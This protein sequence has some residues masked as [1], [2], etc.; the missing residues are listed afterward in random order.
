[1]NKPNILLIY[2]DQMREPMWFPERTVLDRLLPSLARLR[3]GA[4]SFSHCYC[5]SAACSPSRASLLTG[6]YAHQHGIM[7]NV[8]GTATPSLATGFPTWGDSL[9]EFGY[10][11]NWFGK[12]HLTAD[13]DDPNLYG[14]DAPPNALMF[15]PSGK[16]LGVYH[17]PVIVKNFLGWLED[18][19][20]VG[21]WAATVSLFNPHDICLHPDFHDEC[22]NAD[23]I[24]FPAFFDSMPPN[25]ESPDELAQNRKPRLHLARSR[26]FNAQLGIGPDN[27]GY[28]EK[29]AGHANAYLGFHMHLD[30]QVGRIYDVLDKRPTL[31]DNTIIVFVSDHGE[32]NGSHGLRQKGD[33]AY[34][35]GIRVPLIVNDPTGRWTAH[36]QTQRNQLTSMVDVH[37]LLLTLT[38]GGDEWR[39]Q[40]RFAHVADRLDMASIL[41]DPNAPGRRYITHTC[42][43]LMSPWLDDSGAA[44]PTHVLALRTQS[45]KLAVCSHW[46]PGTIE[47]ADDDQDWELYDY[48]DHGGRCE[49]VNDAGAKPQLQT[50]L[51]ELLVSDALPNEL[52]KPLPSPLQPIHKQAI[53]EYVASVSV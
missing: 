32:L 21:P 44:M 38:C 24:E 51:F 47:M 37:A 53:A 34:D 29:W 52:R 26:Q 46:A 1:M 4:V 6:L 2:V 17:D 41:K 49:I 39:T 42:D 30:R 7:T 23:G 8:D 28:R 36:T 18:K 43:Q 22:F 14:F 11:T 31:R 19:A 3:Q 16:G 9:R 5:D 27:I 40:P 33:C 50:E 13:G 20:H 15:D 25:Y 12:L 10:Q 48:A 35:E 45:A